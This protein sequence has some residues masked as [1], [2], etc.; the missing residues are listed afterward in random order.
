MICLLLYFATRTPEGAVAQGRSGDCP[1]NDYGNGVYY[2]GC[3]GE[4]GHA[5]AGF[6]S[7]HPDHPVVAVTTDVRVQNTAGY[8]V[9]TR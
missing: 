2:F 9:V 1:V 4:F 6:I 7:Q 8:W 3:A 5:L